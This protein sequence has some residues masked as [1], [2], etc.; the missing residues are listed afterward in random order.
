[1]RSSLCIYQIL[2]SPP[3]RFDPKTLC[4]PAYS[5]TMVHLFFKLASSV[6]VGVYTKNRGPQCMATGFSLS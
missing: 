6:L 3:V 2:K 5:G 4:V 1:M